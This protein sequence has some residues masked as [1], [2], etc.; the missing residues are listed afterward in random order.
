MIRSFYALSALVFA[1]ATVTSC[2][3]PSCGPG[4]KQMQAANGDVQCI[5]TEQ[6]APATP[7]DLDGGTVE[8]IGGNCESHI[9][10]DPNTTMYD[11]ATGVCVGTGGGGGCAPCPAKPG[12]NNICV[13]GSVVDFQTGMHLVSPT[14]PLRIAVY[15]PLAFLANPT[16][17]MPLAEEPST[18]KGCFTFTVQLPGSGLVAIGVSDPVGT[19][20]PMPLVFGGAGATVVG[21]T[22]Y[23]VDANMVTKATYD[24]YVA[25]E[26]SFGPNGAYVGCYY[27]DAPP[28]P[29]NHLFNETMPVMGVKL[30]ENG[31][32]PATVRYLGPDHLISSALTSTGAIGCAV[33]PSVG[34]IAQYSGTGGGV[35][36]FESAPGASA[37]GVVFINRFHSCDGQPMTG[38]CQ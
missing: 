20:P 6:Q 34:S 33:V 9:K 14:R 12:S 2:N 5:P 16:A 23:H 11:P 15:E 28:P 37:M 22:V 25:A 8:I 4:T 1:A 27:K 30:L 17:A 10:C 31:A 29:T 21:N 3:N 38:A 19:T 32:T 26:A 13:T 24:N 35:T 7:C 18:T 36:K